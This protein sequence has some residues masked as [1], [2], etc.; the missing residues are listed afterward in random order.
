MP[1]LPEVE[2]TVRYLAE[3]VVGKTITRADVLW[4]RTIATHSPKEF[5]SRLT[6]FKIADVFRR[7]KF[8]AVTDR[9][10][11]RFVFVHLRMSGSLDVVSESSPVSTHDRAILHLSNGK[12]IRFNDTRKFGRIYLADDP[13][14]VVG[15]LGIEPLS[16]EFTP[17]VLSSILS[18]RSTRIKGLLL[19]QTAIAGL[20]NIYVDESLWKAAIHPATP[21]KR[22]SPKKCHALHQA[23]VETLSEA[24]ELSGTDFGDHVVEGG[25]YSPVVYGRESEPC[26]R[27]GSI[28]RK[29]TVN[30]RGTHFCPRC[31]RAPAIAM[32]KSPC[33]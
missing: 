33:L 32:R 21:A 27:C 4:P 11:S 3:R 12:T 6:G 19:D 30:Q 31:Q 20:G 5:N 14:L 29:I 9:E 8:I 16:N 28:I 7:G 1:E 10:R 25:M 22:V 15:K 2:S 26:S 13:D 24:I 23:I 17:A 18:Q